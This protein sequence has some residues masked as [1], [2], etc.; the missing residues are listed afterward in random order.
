MAFEESA[1]MN[2]KKFRAIGFLIFA[3]VLHVAA[4]RLAKGQDTDNR[5]KP[6]A[7]PEMSP[8]DQ[9][10]MDRNAEIAL[11]RSAAPET[12]S[13]DA[14]I[15]VLG[16]HGYET[17][18]AGKNGFVCVV[19]RSWM[20]PFDDSEFWNP[21]VRLPVCQNPPAARSH[22]PLTFKTTELALAGRSR[23]QMFDSIKAAFEQKELPL[24]EP[25]SMCYMMSKQ[26]NFGPKFGNADPHLMFW[27]PQPDQI[28]WGADMPESPVDVHQ[29]SPQPITEFAI[30]VAKWS[31]GTAAG[32]NQR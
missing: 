26:Q 24:P 18:V 30:S 10:L 28:S 15:L 27:F 4:L 21:S 17:A 14:T 7:Y 6:R 22:L 8:L 32:A 31:D 3:V 13:R 20:L 1:M 16:R 5:D 9:Y 25:G 29:Y 2:G 12:L 11:A 19:D 23:K